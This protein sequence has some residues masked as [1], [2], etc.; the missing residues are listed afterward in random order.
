M[1]KEPIPFPV[2]LVFVSTNRDQPVMDEVYDDMESLL[3]DLAE[4]TGYASPEDTQSLAD[5]LLQGERITIDQ[6]TLAIF[7]CTS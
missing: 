2:R 5:R 1:D 7:P 3:S 4:A 6:V